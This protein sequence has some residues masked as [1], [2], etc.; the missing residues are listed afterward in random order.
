MTVLLASAR[1]ES[2][3]IK[4]AGQ[5]KAARIYNAAY[6]RDTG[7]YEFLRSMQA[8]QQTFSHNDIIVLQPDSEFCTSI[9]N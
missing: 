6:S 1:A 7:F 2:E 5:S 4:A 3:K 8:Y 9:L